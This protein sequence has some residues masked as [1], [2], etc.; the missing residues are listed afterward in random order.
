M[1]NPNQPQITAFKPSN[2]GGY[3]PDKLSSG[4]ATQ[5]PFQETTEGV[6]KTGNIVP[7]LLRLAMRRL[8]GFGF[9]AVHGKAPSVVKNAVTIGSHGNIK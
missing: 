9:G 1:P 5:Q 7:T 3:R 4:A 2:P 8:P 6:P